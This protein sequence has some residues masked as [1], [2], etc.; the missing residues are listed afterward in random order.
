MIYHFISLLSVASLV[1]RG[2]V[3]IVAAALVVPGELFE[4]CSPRATP[5]RKSPSEEAPDDDQHR[6]KLLI[7]GG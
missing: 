2:C 7:F 6:K 1:P 5:R 3:R 4:P